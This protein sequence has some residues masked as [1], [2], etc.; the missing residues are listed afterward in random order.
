MLLNRI[1]ISFG[2]SCTQVNK[3]T[4]CGSGS[5]KTL[6]YFFYFLVFPNLLYNWAN[7]VTTRVKEILT[8]DLNVRRCG[9]A[10]QCKVEEVKH[11]ERLYRF[12]LTFYL[13]STVT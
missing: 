5:R 12:L 11:L 7:G 6:D 2:F 8:G 13:K 9:L 1:I 4:W 10:E 3:F